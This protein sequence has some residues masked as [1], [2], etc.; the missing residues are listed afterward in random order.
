MV[1]AISV[2]IIDL[3]LDYVGLYWKKCSMA[4]CWLISIV[5]MLSHTPPVLT[6][7]VVGWENLIRWRDTW[8]HLSSWRRCIETKVHHV[9]FR[10]AWL[11]L[12][13]HDFYLLRWRQTIA[14][15][16]GTT[17]VYVEV[18]TVQ[19]TII[20]LVLPHASIIWGR[21]VTCLFLVVT[22]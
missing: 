1:V 7:V 17:M 4:M 12:G 16:F 10:L 22:V 13:L 5:V 9:M 14:L 3:G 18:L 20:H 8:S 6:W 19:R 2:H 21:S 15:S 11:S